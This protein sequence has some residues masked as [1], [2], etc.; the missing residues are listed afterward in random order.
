MQKDEE[1][2]SDSVILFGYVCQTEPWEFGSAAFHMN[3]YD[4]GIK[5]KTKSLEQFAK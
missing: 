4:K 3:I 2:D 5:T 1:R